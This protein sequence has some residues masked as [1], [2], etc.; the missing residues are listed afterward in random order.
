MESV[1]CRVHRNLAAE[2][3]RRWRP[4]C[5][6]ADGGF[7]SEAGCAVCAAAN[8][9]C[10]G[11]VKMGAVGAGA[12][13][14][15][16]QIWVAAAGGTRKLC[17]S[18]RRRL[19]EA[20]G[21]QHGRILCAVA[22]VAAS[23]LPVAAGGQH[24]KS[25]HYKS[26]TLS[27]ERVGGDKSR[28]VDITLRASWSTEF[29]AFQEQVDGGVIQPG[30]EI[31]LMGLGNPVLFFGDGAESYAMLN[32]KVIAVDPV[33]QAWRGTATVRHTYPAHANYTAHIGGC[34]RDPHV[35]NSERGYFQIATGVHLASNGSRSPQLAVLARQY[36][37]AGWLDAH[38]NG[39]VI[40]AFDSG[41]HPNQAA[42]GRVS[43]LK[44]GVYCARAAVPDLCCVIHAGMQGR[45]THACM[46]ACWHACMYRWVHALDIA[47]GSYKY[48]CIDADTHARCICMHL[49]TD[50]RHR[51]V[52]AACVNVYA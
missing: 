15:G 3:D 18:G 49:C 11:E 16:V 9:G 14:Q 20:A 1:Q 40:A 51:W 12:R 23:M 26:A 6:A 45:H 10:G 44:F 42:M 50:G 25:G 30:Q 28:T 46:L 27:W 38:A 37:R 2:D 5:T 41:L 52:T 47:V 48:V 35:R 19:P 13:A 17:R 39:F 21:I 7:L 22:V 32:A 29:S 43:G 31:R 24:W 34:C 33:V 4:D 8:R 36:V